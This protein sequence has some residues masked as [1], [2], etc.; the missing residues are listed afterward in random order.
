[1]KKFYNFNVHGRY[2][3]YIWGETN[4]CR[5][6]LTTNIL[7]LMEKVSLRYT[8]MIEISR[9]PKWGHFCG[10]AKFT[11]FRFGNSRFLFNDEWDAKTDKARQTQGN[12]LFFT[13]N[14][15]WIAHIRHVLMRGNIE[16]VG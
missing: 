8:T 12:F 1:M 6:A 7:G 9:V 10:T 16:I 15:F 13:K 3:S 14:N 5:C 4:L 2:E 11:I